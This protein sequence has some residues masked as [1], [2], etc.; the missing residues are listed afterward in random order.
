MN[1]LNVL[2]LRNVVCRYDTPSWVVFPTTV[3]LK[4]HI[5]IVLHHGLRGPSNSRNAHFGIRYRLKVARIRSNAITHAGGNI[6]VVFLSPSFMLNSATCFQCSSPTSLCWNVQTM[7]SCTL[8]ILVRCFFPPN[9]F[10]FMSSW[11]AQGKMSLIHANSG[12]WCC[13]SLYLLSFLIM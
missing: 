3:L 13:V 6:G 5:I 2:Q 11:L 4:V 1:T 7:L 9:A 8:L 12:S 10:K